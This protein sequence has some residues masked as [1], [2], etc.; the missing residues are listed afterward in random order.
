MTGGEID[1]LKAATVPEPATALS[2]EVRGRVCV[3]IP[4]YNEAQ[5]VAEVVRG[6]RALYP[7]VVVVDDGS[8]DATAEAART[9]GASVLR[10]VINRG[11]GAALQTGIEF[12]LRRGADFIVTFDSDGQHCVEDIAALVAPIHLGQ[13]HISLGSRFLG[14]VENITRTRRLLLRAGVHFTRAVSRV[15][16][17]DTH[18]GLRAFSKDAARRIHITLDRMA[19]ASELIDQIRDSGLPYGEVPVHVRYTAYSLEKGQSGLGAVRIL[20]DYCVKRLTQ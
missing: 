15:R 1:H 10:H 20:F 4:A 12:A 14:R 7:N 19:H 13:W 9:A 3:V 17:T 6:V 5:S 16:I 2:A 8:K 18:N 11:Q